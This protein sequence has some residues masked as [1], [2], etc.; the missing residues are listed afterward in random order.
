MEYSSFRWN[1]NIFRTKVSSLLHYVCLVLLYIYGWMGWDLLG[2]DSVFKSL[3][4]A[5]CMSCITAYIWMDGMMGSP[6]F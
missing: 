1:T 6:R 4:A 3:S 2:S 5:L